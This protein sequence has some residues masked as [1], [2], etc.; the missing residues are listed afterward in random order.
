MLLWLQVLKFSGCEGARSAHASVRLS[1][2]C[3]THMNFQVTKLVRYCGLCCRQVAV[4]LSRT[5]SARPHLK[6]DAQNNHDMSDFLH[7]RK[8]GLCDGS[9]QQLHSIQTLEPGPTS[10]VFYCVTCLRRRLHCVF[11]LFLAASGAVAPVFSPV[12]HIILSGS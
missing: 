9:R 3:S 7:L 2:A 4:R 1:N 5:N 10:L 6:I 12:L 8:H 11:L